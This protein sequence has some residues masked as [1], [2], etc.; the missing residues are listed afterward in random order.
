MVSA[1]TSR[2]RARRTIAFDLVSL[3]RPETAQD[4]SIWVLT[5]AQLARRADRPADQAPRAEKPAARRRLPL[6][7]YRSRLVRLDLAQRLL[8]ERPLELR[9]STADAALVARTARAWPS[10]P[11]SQAAEIL[12]ALLTSM[13][14]PLREI[15]S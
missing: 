6:R 10:D 15:A 5:D 8:D 2:S 4:G 13:Q 11:R 7:T 1:R 3:T 14:R 9:P 12:R